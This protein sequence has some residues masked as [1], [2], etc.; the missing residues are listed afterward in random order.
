MD[1]RKIQLR[2][3]NGAEIVSFMSPEQYEQFSEEFLLETRL[4][5]ERLRVARLRSEEA[6]R[7]HLISYV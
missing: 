6:A 4:E 1:S 2:L 5:H 7:R 3:S